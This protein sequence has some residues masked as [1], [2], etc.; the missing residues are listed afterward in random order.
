[1]CN[2]PTWMEFVT[3]QHAEGQR[4]VPESLRNFKQ[5]TQERSVVTSLLHRIS[6]GCFVAIKIMEPTGSQWVPLNRTTILSDG[7][8]L[9][10]SHTV[11]V[12]VQEKKVALAQ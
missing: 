12:L 9:C 7:A 2:T 4:L 6:A 3:T 5:F 8:A 10:C 1:M 11:L